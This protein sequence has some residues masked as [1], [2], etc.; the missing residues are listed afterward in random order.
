MFYPPPS[1]IHFVLFLSV[2]FFTY[3]SSHVFFIISF[4][5]AWP[6]RLVQGRNVTKNS[7]RQ[8][9]GRWDVQG[10]HSGTSGPRWLS[11]LV[12]SR[13]TFLSG[14]C[15]IDDIFSR[16]SSAIVLFPP[17]ENQSFSLSLSFSTNHFPSFRSNY[18]GRFPRNI[19]PFGTHLKIP[20]FSLLLFFLTRHFCRS[21]SSP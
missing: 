5:T 8:Q 3:I 16:I 9:N 17:A 13:P 11:P 1:I 15:F 2:F 7:R 14:V 4:F 20:L 12:I 21:S 6:L 10:I 18:H 19:P